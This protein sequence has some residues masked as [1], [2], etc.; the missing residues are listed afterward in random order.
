MS[1]PQNQLNNEQPV[2][3][4]HGSTGKRSI[5]AQGQQSD[6]S[7]IENDNDKSRFDFI[8]SLGSDSAEDEILN[9]QTHSNNE[10]IDENVDGGPDESAPQGYE[11]AEQPGNDYQEYADIF[12]E[13]DIRES[14]QDYLN[15]ED[16]ERT[17][18][19][20][21]TPSNDEVE[22]VSADSDDSHVKTPYEK[23]AELQKEIVDEE[24]V[25]MDEAMSA[26][27][28]A[29][30]D[31]NQ[32]A[33]H[34][35]QAASSEADAKDD[36]EQ[37]HN[38]KPNDR[39]DPVERL[40]KNIEA[41]MQTRHMQPPANIRQG[42]FS[43]F[44]QGNQTQ[45]TQS[46]PSN[47]WTEQ[48]PASKPSVSNEQQQEMYQPKTTAQEFMQNMDLSL[49]QTLEQNATAIENLNQTL[50]NKTNSVDVTELNQQAK[51]LAEDTTLFLQALSKDLERGKYNDEDSINQIN[52]SL[53]K[54]KNHDKSDFNL[55]NIEAI[56]KQIQ[57]QIEKLMEKFSKKQS[58]GMG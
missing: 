3:Q 55:E 12:G 58:M 16:A 24:W 37:Q 31:T 9:S 10:M 50:A 8:D 5:P 33:Q 20:S 4:D 39:N 7:Q 21:D 40:V 13:A 34:D 49:L 30:E 53:S 27:D 43:S 22:K 15:E 14:R 54:L 6:H 18:A 32:T 2:H 44:G 42:M 46:T 23:A 11:Y 38:D 35:K 56:T 48:A 45:Q 52:A 41:M 57:E 29:A 1:E 19:Q 47:P 25:D 26:G 36:T 17:E 51:M 28:T